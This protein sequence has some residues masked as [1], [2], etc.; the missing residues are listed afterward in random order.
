MKNL[1]DKISTYL[2]V[3]G[4]Q[5]K[6]E[7]K[8]PS[9]FPETTH[10]FRQSVCDYHVVIVACFV[11]QEVGNICGSCRPWLVLQPSEISFYFILVDLNLDLVWKLDIDP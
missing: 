6:E 2:Y 4:N 1:C 5:D 8:P 3:F 9:N 10:L 11:P 7:A